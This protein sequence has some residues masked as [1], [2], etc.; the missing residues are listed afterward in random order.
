MGSKAN[1]FE[2]SLNALI[3]NNTAVANIG[4]TAGLQPSATGGSLYIALET[5]ATVAD[6]ATPGTETTYT[7]YA[8]VPV[9]RNS[10]GFTVSGNS[11]V[12]AAAIQFP[13]C[14]G[15]TANIRYA[16]V[17]TAATGGTRLYWGQ[18]NADLA[19]SNG[20]TPEIPAGE[21]SLTED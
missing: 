7:G 10:A 3:F 18:L 8:R 9:T 12:N 5:D 11:V 2:T 13:A 14:T 1:G 17:Y 16:S 19:V 21:F 4:D 6:D 15:G 20:I